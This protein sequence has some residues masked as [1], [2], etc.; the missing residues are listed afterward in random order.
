MGGRT[1]FL[2][3]ELP[4]LPR[5]NLFGALSVNM[6]LFIYVCVCVGGKEYLKEKPTPIPNSALLQNY[7]FLS[8]ALI[9]FSVKGV[10]HSFL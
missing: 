5:S 1:V 4:S 9:Y 7:S 8:L 10:T 2:G 6:F 3:V